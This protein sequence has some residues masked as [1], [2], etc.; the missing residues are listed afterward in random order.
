[1]KPI[2]NVGLNHKP[3][4]P[5]YGVPLLCLRSIDRSKT[6]ATKMDGKAV[7][8]FVSCIASVAKARVYNTVRLKSELMVGL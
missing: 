5:R 2:P 7:L 1:M 8:A 6:L 3:C 4:C